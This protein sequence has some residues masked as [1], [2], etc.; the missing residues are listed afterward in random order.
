MKTGA[1]DTIKKIKLK[2]NSYCVL[3]LLEHQSSVKYLMSFRILEY[4]ILIWKDY[5]KE[6]I[7]YK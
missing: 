2:D 1:S 5:T 6:K 3:C 4:M 7:S